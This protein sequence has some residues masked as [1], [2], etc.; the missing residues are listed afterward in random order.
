[1]YNPKLRHELIRK[2]HF[3]AKARGM[4]MTHYL[5]KIVE[6]ALVSEPEPPPYEPSARKKTRRNTL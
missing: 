1:M 2:L 3:A 5:N 6:E 4:P